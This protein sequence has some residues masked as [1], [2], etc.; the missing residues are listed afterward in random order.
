MTATHDPMTE[1]IA[2]LTEPWTIKVD[3]DHRARIPYA[4]VSVREFP[5]LIDMLRGHITPDTGKT[6]GGANDPASRSVL[7]LKSLDLLMHI[8]DIVRAWLGEWRIPT[9]DIRDDIR[10]FADRLETLHRA[11]SIDQAVYE[12]LA[13]Q[14]D[15]WVVRIWDLIE[16]PRRI[17][18]RGASCPRCERAKITNADGESADN[19]LVLWRDG[20]EPTAECQWED[21]AAIWVGEDGLKALGREL[22]E[23][24]NIGAL[25]A[26]SDT[27]ITTV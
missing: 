8:E 10:A 20:Q 27:Q 26:D 18:L 22:G 9:G 13:A 11:D 7:D 25:T 2:R 3:I 21:C 17:A 14:P 23:E 6:M 24:F 5:P 15:V 1:A 12:G 19:L 16:P 4:D